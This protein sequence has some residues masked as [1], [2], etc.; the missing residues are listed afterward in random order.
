[1]KVLIASGIYPPDIGGPAT[2]AKILV[3]ELSNRGDKATV[4]TY[5][6][7]D[8]PSVYGISRGIPK[9]IRHLLYFIKV[10]ILSFSHDKVLALD[11]TSAGLPVALASIITRKAYAVRIVGD[12]AWEQGI[13]RFGVHE[14]LDDFLKLEYGGSISSLRKIQRFVVRNSTKVIVPSAY[15][16]DVVSSWKTT[17]GDIEI[18]PNS[19]S[20]VNIPDKN[21]ARDKLKLT[22][23]VILTV[24]RL[25]KWKGHDM[26]IRLMSELYEEH[27]AT[28][29]IAGDG[30]ERQILED[31]SRH[32]RSKTAV[33]FAGTLSKT[34]LAEYI[35]AAD[36]FVLNTAYEGFSHVLLE[37]MLSG[38]PVI[39]TLAGG[40]KEIVRDGENAL[41]ARYNDKKEWVNAITKLS[42]DERLREKLSKNAKGDAAKYTTSSMI[43]KT[44][45]LLH[46]L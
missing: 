6:K 39:T 28:L 26:L 37:I 3:S 21:I 41:V 15:L 30:P 44:Q 16:K 13:Q 1:M 20:Y 36:I 12:Y 8:K 19:I 43:T 14:L 9:G 18:I 11:A 17:T 4:L 24:G 22:G 2:Y 46:D 31:I 5:G 32:A 38:L 7:Q 34:E 27:G 42:N 10:I 35:A 25:V 33:I 29:V 45:K 23:L 40:N